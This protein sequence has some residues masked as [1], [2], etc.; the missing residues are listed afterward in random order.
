MQHWI[1]FDLG[2]TKMLC[3]VYNDAFELKSRVK[4]KTKAH[5][6]AEAGIERIEKTITTAMEEAGISPKDIGGICIGVPGMVN[7]I[8]GLII[9]APNLGWQNVEIIKR[10]KKKFSVPIYLLNDVDSGIYGEYKFGAGKKS[11][12]LLGVFPGT[13]VGGGFIYDDTIFTGKTM[14][15]FEIGHIPVVSDGPTC[16]C[17]G[18][19]CLEAVSSKLAIAAEAVR[20]AYR[21]DAPNLYKRVGTDVASVSSSVL[22]EAIEKGDSVVEEIVRQAARNVGKGI[23]M[24]VNILLPDTVV[25][26]GGLVEA[27][28]KIYLSEI[29]SEAKR[30]CLASFSDAF[31]VKTAKCGD[32]AAIIGAAAWAKQKTTD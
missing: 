28:P 30:Q 6:D 18:K 12:R 21:G 24:L 27:M 3:G 14:A 29:T 2:G 31:T 23:G 4:K 8:D 22:A 26:G 13:G 25:L 1:G 17:G 10:L 9:D 32:D 5:G 16:G 19:G 7:L 20:A 11:S 15:A